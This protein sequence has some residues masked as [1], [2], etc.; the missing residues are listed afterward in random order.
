MAKRK[1]Q[2]RLSNGVGSPAKS[3]EIKAPKRSAKK[4]SK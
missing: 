1:P 2:S 4:G 3:R